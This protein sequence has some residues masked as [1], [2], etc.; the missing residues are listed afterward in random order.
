MNIIDYINTESQEVNLLSPS[1][2]VGEK[3]LSSNSIQWLNSLVGDIDWAYSL[4]QQN[5][6]EIALKV[7]N[8]EVISR[9]NLSTEW[10]DISADKISISGSTT[11]SSWYDP[12]DKLE[13]SDVG[14]LAF[15]DRVGESDIYDKAVSFAK[16]WTTVVSWWYIKTDVLDV[17]DIFA[18]N[19]SATW[20]ITWAT[21]KTSTSSSRVEMANDKVTLYDWWTS[22]YMEWA[23]LWWQWAVWFSWYVAIK[24]FP[25]LFATSI[26]ST[27]KVADKWIKVDIA[28]TDYWL[29]ATAA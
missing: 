20:T 17:D 19:I 10:I 8:D 12:S 7:G 11:F 24:W 2:W 25:A 4:I 22:S 13:S 21:L 15:Q 14:D 29:H 27:S 18:Q 16:L 5:E 28:W 9:I 23:T 26:S 3:Q 1:P 6:D